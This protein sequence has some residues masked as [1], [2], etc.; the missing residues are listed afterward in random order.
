[1]G[2]GLAFFEGLDEIIKDLKGF[3]DD[4]K[5]D[6]AK[7]LDSELLKIEIQMKSNASKAF[8]ESS[9]MVNSISHKVTI[10]D[11]GVSASV[12]V[13]D[14]GMKTNSMDRLVSGRR[15]TAPMLALFYEA[16]IRPHST[17]KG[18]RLAHTSGKKEKGQEG[19]IHQGSAPIPFLTSAFDVAAPSIFDEI[20]R[21]LKLL[22]D[23]K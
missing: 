6:V 13:Y 2:R 8:D 22:A 15:I 23:K 16:G 3:G 20:A 5:K 4:I 14:M 19:R 17:A 12:G 21:S 11:G 10:Y 1:M 18:A 7:S 9:V